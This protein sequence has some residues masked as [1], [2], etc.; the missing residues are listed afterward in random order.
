MC[1]KIVLKYAN[2]LPIPGTSSVFLLNVILI[3]QNFF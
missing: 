3:S 2:N 1:T